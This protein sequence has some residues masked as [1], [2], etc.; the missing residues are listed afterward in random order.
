MHISDTPKKKFCL[1]KKKK[2]AGLMG[3]ACN[4]STREAGIKDRRIPGSF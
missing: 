4:V 1:K 3:Y 2:K